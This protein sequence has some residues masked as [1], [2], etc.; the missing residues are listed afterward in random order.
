GLT[1]NYGELLDFRYELGGTADIIVKDRR[2]IERLFDNL[3]YRTK[4]K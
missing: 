2:L 1:T 4:A 3:R